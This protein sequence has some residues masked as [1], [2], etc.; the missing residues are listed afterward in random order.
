MIDMPL[1]ITPMISAPTTTPTILPD[2][3]AIRVAVTFARR[4]TTGGSTVVSRRASLL[5]PPAGLAASGESAVSSD[6]DDGD[7]KPADDMDGGGHG[8]HALSRDAFVGAIGLCDIRAVEVM[9]RLDL[10]FAVLTDPPLWVQVTGL[11]LGVRHAYAL[12]TLGN[13]RRRFWE[14]PVAAHAVTFAAPCALCVS[15]GGCLSQPACWLTHLRI[16]PSPVTDPTH[17]FALQ[18]F[19]LSDK[20]D[21]VPLCAVHVPAWQVRPC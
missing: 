11:P 21:R 1:F 18:V 8:N 12:V 2:P 3:P 9:I 14:E 4:H 16:T 13:Q 15:T 17:T 6:T 19:M 20:G 7:D 5:H 10:V